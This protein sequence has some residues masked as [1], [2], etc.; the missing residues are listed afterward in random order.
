MVPEQSLVERQ[1]GN[2]SCSHPCFLSDLCAALPKHRLDS[3]T[4]RCFVRSYAR[5]VGFASSQT[6]EHVISCIDHGK[7]LQ[8]YEISSHWDTHSVEF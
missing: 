4:R 2:F 1:P 5:N 7:E 6:T 8:E 3:G